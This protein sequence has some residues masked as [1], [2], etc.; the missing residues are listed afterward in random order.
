MQSMVQETNRDVEWFNFYHKKFIKQLKLILI[1]TFY[2]FN[3]Y[4]WGKV[5]FS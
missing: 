4:S 5:S 3:I 2:P 1:H